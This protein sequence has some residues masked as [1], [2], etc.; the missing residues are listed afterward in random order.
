MTSVQRLA[1]GLTGLA[2]VASVAALWG[3]SEPWAGIDIG[4]VGAAVFGLALVAGAWLFARRAN[5]VFPGHMS[6]AERRAWVGLL[7]V[8]IMLASYLRQLWALSG[9]AVVPQYIQGLFAHHFVQRL[10]VLILAWSLISHLIGR[11]AGGVETDE[12]DI[13]L[14]HRA[15]RAGDWAL[16]LIVIAGICVLASVPAAQLAWWLAPIVLANLLIGL[17]IT[18]ALVEHVALAVIYRRA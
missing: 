3:P 7:F 15:D 17:L 6:V 14:R 4:A 9:E 12:R 5:D 16:T 1:A 10:F 8:A 11:A 13:R 2:V 18:K